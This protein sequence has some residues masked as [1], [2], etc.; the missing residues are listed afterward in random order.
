VRDVELHRHEAAGGDPRRGDRRI[1][2]EGRQRIARERP[3][4][5]ENHRERCEVA[6]HR[7]L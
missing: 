7:R 2:A 1:G 5:G 4:G 6:H 3:A